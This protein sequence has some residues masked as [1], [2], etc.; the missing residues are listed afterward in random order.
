MGAANANQVYNHQLGTREGGFGEGQREKVQLL[1]SYAHITH[2][3]TQTHVRTHMHTHT[4][5]RRGPETG[6]PPPRNKFA[7]AS[8]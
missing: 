2:A 3:H 5:G 7:N 1:A 4:K 6:A 8:I